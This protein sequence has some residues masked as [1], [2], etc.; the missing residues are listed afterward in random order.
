MLRDYSG[1]LSCCCS[2]EAR[3]KICLLRKEEKKCF[4]FLFRNWVRCKPVGP[5]GR[6]GVGR[7]GVASGDGTLNLAD[8]TQPSAAG[9]TPASRHRRCRRLLCEPAPGA[10]GDFED[11]H[12]C[13]CRLYGRYR[14]G[15]GRHWWG[16]DFRAREL[17]TA[18]D[19]LSVYRRYARAR[20]GDIGKRCHRLSAFWLVFLLSVADPRAGMLALLDSCS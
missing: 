8:G 12:P 15:V 2:W 14:L 5:R 6:G 19:T 7:V 20:D 18:Y 16:L 9:A 13:Q 3:G 11:C 17:L 4:I 1:L 10:F